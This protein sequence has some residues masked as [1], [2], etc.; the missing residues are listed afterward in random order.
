MIKSA[1]LIRVAIVASVVGLLVLLSAGE[2]ASWAA[3][4]QN[5]KRETLPTFT[6]TPD[7]GAPT[8]TPVPPTDTPVPP[9][10][11]KTPAPKPRA[12]DTP[13]PTATPAQAV[14]VTV[15]GDTQVYAGPGFEYAVM[16]SLRAGDQVVIVGRNA[17]SSWWQILFQ[18]S[19]GWV[20]GE[21][22]NVIPVAYEVPVVNVSPPETANQAPSTLPEAGGVPLW[23]GGGVFLLVSGT[24]ALLAGSRARRRAEVGRR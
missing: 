12:T 5:E 6:F 7:P 18:E 21:A 8:D 4:G 20:V 10:P 22:L 19:T 1:T 23:L 16:G 11:T 2:Y 24:L 9:P 17:D 13:A 3:P 14:Q 15:S